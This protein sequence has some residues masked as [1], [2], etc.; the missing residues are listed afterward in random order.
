MTHLPDG[1]LVIE[2]DG[3]RLWRILENLYN[4]CCKYAYMEGSRVYVT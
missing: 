3:R 2:A 4:N 1:K